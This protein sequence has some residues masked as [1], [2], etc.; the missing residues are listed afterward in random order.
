MRMFT[1]V[2]AAAALLTA[3]GK[4]DE[5]D[6]AAGACST[7]VPSDCDTTDPSTADIDCETS[8]TGPMA[9]RI[10]CYCCDSMVTISQCSFGKCSSSPED[11]EARCAGESIF[12][13]APEEPE[14]TYT[15]SFCFDPS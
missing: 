5:G 10:T 2:V 6:S 4:K 11:C 14:D 15:G 7:S 9:C 1:L 12:G 13:P 3:C 8:G